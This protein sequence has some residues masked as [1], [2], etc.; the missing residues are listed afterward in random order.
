MR[1]IISESRLEGS[2]FKFFDKTLKI[3]EINYLHGYIK[4]DK[5]DVIEDKNSLIFFIG[6]PLDGDNLFR[7]YDCG[8]FE[9]NEYAESLCPMLNLEIFYWNMFNGVFDNLWKTAFKKWIKDNF[10]LNVKTI[11]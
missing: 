5:G 6:E 7:W 4:N 1:Y 11:N 9:G 10:N 2:M 3:D 8:Y